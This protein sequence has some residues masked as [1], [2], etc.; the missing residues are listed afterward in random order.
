MIIYKYSSIKIINFQIQ[1]DIDLKATNSNFAMI[2]RSFEL[3]P[4]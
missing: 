4:G 3:K 2:L 1:V